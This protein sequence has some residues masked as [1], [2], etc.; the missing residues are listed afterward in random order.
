MPSKIFKNNLINEYL[1]AFLE[2]IC[3]KTE[4]YYQIDNNAY[5][6]MLYNNYH[7]EFIEE[8]KQHYNVSKQHYLTREL[9]YNSF[10]NILRQ[11]CKSNEI[12][13]EK[14]INYNKSKYS[15][16]YLIYYKKI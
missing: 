1:F 13:Y 2:K 10:V 9:T 15:I 4:N 16:I 3:L 8:L 5:K 14:N 6:K 7:I 11:I 12:E